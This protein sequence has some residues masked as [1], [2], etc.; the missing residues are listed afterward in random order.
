MTKEEIY[1]EIRAAHPDWTDEQVWTQV[2]IRISGE[3]TISLHPDMAANDN[4]IVKTII[5]M[6]ERWIHDNL[7]YIWER[8]KVWFA[9]ILNNIIDW[10][11]ERG[12]SFI[13]NIFA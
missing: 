1:E 11:K 10:F 3:G 6:A 5:E 8:V 7:P 9:N 13:T 12:W 4:E 2:S